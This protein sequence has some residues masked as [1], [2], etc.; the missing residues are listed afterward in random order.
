MAIISNAILEKPI[1]A[2]IPILLDF[3]FFKEILIIIS[4]F[5]NVEYKMALIEYR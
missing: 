5:E 3:I 4:G 2:T 1:K